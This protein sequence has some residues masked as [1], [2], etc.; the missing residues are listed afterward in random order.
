M[1]KLMIFLALMALSIP[2]P[3]SFSAPAQAANPNVGFCKDYV[4]SDPTL[5]PN[6]NRGECI[7]YLT[8]F[9]NSFKNGHANGWAVHECDYLLENYPDEFYAIWD[10]KQECVADLR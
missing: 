3:L 6:L 8:T 4:G 10:S 9:D 2:A 5:D 7:S 1:T